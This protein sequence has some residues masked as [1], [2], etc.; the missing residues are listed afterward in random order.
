[1]R[2]KLLA[3]LIVLLAGLRCADEDPLPSAGGD[4]SRLEKNKRRSGSRTH[5]QEVHEYRLGGVELNSR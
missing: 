3:G 1:M 5:L 2:A 4:E